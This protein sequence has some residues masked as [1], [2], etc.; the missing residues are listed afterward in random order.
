[1]YIA[2]YIRSCPWVL[3]AQ[4]IPINCSAR[5][6]FGFQLLQLRLTPWIQRQ[7]LVG[8]FNPSEKY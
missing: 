5:L 8:G 7:N 1:M 6:Q 4:Q 2:T 3:L